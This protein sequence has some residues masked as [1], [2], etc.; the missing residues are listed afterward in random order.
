MIDRVIEFSA[1]RP[2]L[3]VALTALAAVAG[4][5]SLRHT[6]VDA[7]PDLGDTQVIVYST[8]ERSPDLIEDQVTSPIVN[9]LLGAPGVRSVRGI[10]D[11][12]SSFVY[13]IFEE[14][15]DP[16]RARSRVQEYVSGVQSTLPPGVKTQ[17]GPDATGLGWV[18]QYV[19]TDTAG[20]HSLD[21]LR[22]I[23]DWYLRY[24]LRSVP[25]VAEVASV[26]GFEREFQVNLDPNR[27]RAYGIPLT[28]VAEAVGAG[29]SETGGRVIELAG[30]EYMIRGRGYARTAADL[31]Q[32]L[33]S[34]EESDRPVRIRDVGQVAFGPQPR[35]GVTDLD[36]KGEAVS[37]IVVMRQG[38]NALEVIRAVKQRLRQIEPGLPAGVRVVPIYDRSRLIERSAATLRSTVM[39]VVLTVS[40]VIFLFLWHVPSAAIP[41]ITIPATLLIV[42]LPLRAVGIGADIMALGGIAIA[43]GALVDAAIVIVE[44]SHKRMEEA[45]RGEAVYD[46]RA[47][48][49]SAMRE[50]GRP[51]FFTL[52]VLGLSFAPVLALQAEEGR[53]F[54]PLAIAKIGC[55]LVAAVL[56]VT[57]DPALRVWF[58]GLRERRFEPRWLCRAVNA[59][60]VGKVRPES[61][62]PLSRTLIR[63]YEPVV[64]WTLVHKGWVIAGALA[65]VL[66][67][68]PAFRGLGS[69][70][71][72][73]IDEGD[74]LYMP[75]TA[76]GISIAEARQL[77]ENAGRTL[78]RFPEVDRV[79]GKAGRA[80]TATDPAPLSMLEIIVTLR[81]R[82]QW[83][84]RAT[85]Y[86]SW[87]AAWMK[88]ALRRVTSDRI[89]RRDL[90]TAMD[91]ALATQGVVNAWT[92]PVRGR[93][94]MLTTGIRTPI[95]L[96]IS[97][98]DA[99]EL[100]RLGARA[101]SIL[102]S[103]A[104]TR[105][106]F[107]D[108]LAG[109]RYLDIDWDRER[110]A[111]NGL[112]MADA[113][114][115]VENAIGGQEVSFA[116]EARARYPIRV[117]YMRDFRSDPEAI[118]GVLVSSPSGRRQ[119]PLGEL[120][121]VHFVDGPAMLRNEDGLLTLYVYVDTDRSDLAAY[122]AAAGRKL[123]AQ[124]SLPAGY[125]LD[126]SGQFE[127]MRRTR[128][129]MWTI[130]PLTLSAIV[131]LLWLNTRSVA[132][133][134]M[135]L[136]AVP[137]SAIGAVWLL[138]LLGYQLSVAVWVG[139]IALL[140]VDAETGVFMLLY[141]DLA[142]ARARAAGRLGST[143]ELR[144]A[145][146]EGAA[147]RIRPKFMTV[148]TMLIGLAPVLWAD[149]TGA[150]VTK[151]IAAP[152][153]GGIVTSFLME[154]LVYPPLY[155]LWSRGQESWKTVPAPLRRGSAA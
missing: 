18:L 12:G 81:P 1:R 74:L 152:L 29:N 98:P 43:V 109:G 62:H 3:I 11:F 66:L 137:F 128:A 34:G 124:L 94:D 113:Q 27:L 106:A 32:I 144:A 4:W 118:A 51:A 42:F 28:R 49:L 89:S 21:E 38:A 115:A 120:A 141:L 135:V 44:Q 123:D 9:A 131:L 24:R 119:I 149:G 41:V 146:A 35:R 108:R 45:A 151:R 61:A 10:S 68:A 90:V 48:V 69:E 47:V 143:S 150:E 92:M 26:G 82:E 63:L 13:V 53:M 85:W 101:E 46:R 59:I 8:W 125:S 58:A 91:R 110:L 67:T 40:I 76:P 148:A 114:A 100:D 140:G 78:K 57:L 105:S 65:A 117:R 112:S 77:L 17:L 52:V 19:V 88:P 16:Y 75:T 134:L 31:E 33:L 80:A 138:H 56:A 96:K 7:I 83:S 129:A 70:F 14:G 127:A 86:D 60:V 87:A 39:E 133:T 126:W 111:R 107:A 132:K 136:A 130:V 54:R 145:I 116:I 154:L 6:P 95:G 36:G 104:G 84:T 139:V 102:R 153:A 71:L 73:E 50:V 5:Q 64:N 93:V 25:G 103:V 2:G 20:A 22:A 23:Q 99:S 55:M 121:T 97:G 122:V 30:A 15:T 79:L 147:R 37:G 142:C 155:E 72:P